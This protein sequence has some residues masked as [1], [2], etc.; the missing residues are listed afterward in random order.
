MFRNVVFY[1]SGEWLRKT[2]KLIFNCAISC[3][4]R[5][6]SYLSKQDVT[7]QDSVI[8]FC[9]HEKLSPKTFSQSHKR[10]RC[11]DLVSGE[12]RRLNQNILE[13]WVRQS[14]ASSG[15]FPLWW[16]LC[17]ELLTK[18]QQSK[19]AMW[20]NVQN[21]NTKNFCLTLSSVALAKLFMFPNNTWLLH[22]LQ[23]MIFLL[24]N[25][26]NCLLKMLFP[27]SQSWKWRNVNNLQSKT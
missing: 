24:T 20:A 15:E 25:R 7:T 6:L 9:K 16:F 22:M 19:H 8:R 18:P 27:V 5:V 21:K 11:D 3:I 4:I 17:D 23:L 13:S 2:V 12:Q 14:E 1:I 10:E 26:F